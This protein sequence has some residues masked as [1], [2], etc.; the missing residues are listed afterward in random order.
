MLNKDD[1]WLWNN[2]YQFAVGHWRWRSN[3]DGDNGDKLC[4]S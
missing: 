3:D 4:D 1:Y 2:V